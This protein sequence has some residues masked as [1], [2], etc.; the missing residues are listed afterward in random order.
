MICP[1]CGYDN[2]PGNDTCSRCLCDLTALDRPAP[3]DRVE[4]SLMADTVASLKPRAPVVVRNR[5]VVSDALRSLLDNDIGALLVVD[6]SETLVGIF[7]ERDILT[8]VA[9][10]ATPLEEL[11]VEQFMTPKPEA[12]SPADTLAFAL[13]K[14]DVGG[15]RHLPVVENG[16]PVGIISVRDLIRHMTKMCR[17]KA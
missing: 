11:A 15:Y 17:D 10:L 3:Q 7:S 5:A 9:G 4:H 16:K 12:V 14:M 2:L 8:K 1:R 13:H 6:E